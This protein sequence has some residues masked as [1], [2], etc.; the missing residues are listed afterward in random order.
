M[1]DT[2]VMSDDCLLALATSGELLQDQALLLDFLEPW[3][4]MAKYAEEILVCMY[5]L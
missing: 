4:G 2:L 5:L 3:Y 1:P